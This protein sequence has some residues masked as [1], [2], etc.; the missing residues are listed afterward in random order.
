MGPAMGNSM[1]NLLNSR[2]AALAEMANANHIT[3]VGDGNWFRVP[4]T[5]WGQMATRR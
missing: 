3:P 2:A 1:F 4:S 5:A